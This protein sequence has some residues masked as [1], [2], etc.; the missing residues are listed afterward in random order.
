[1][2]LIFFSIGDLFSPHVFSELICK[3]V[4]GVIV[5]LTMKVTV[6]VTVTM[7][8]TVTVMM[9]VMLSFF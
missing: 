2:K 7:A 4:L 8:V 5:F 9:T 1:M 6:T 3:Q